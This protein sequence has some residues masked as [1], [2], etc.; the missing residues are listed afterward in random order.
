MENS[1]SLMIQRLL[2]LKEFKR[3]GEKDILRSLTNQFECDE[4]EAAKD[5][6]KFILNIKEA[7]FVAE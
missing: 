4:T 6:D 2:Y 3:H 7:G 1:T 5:F